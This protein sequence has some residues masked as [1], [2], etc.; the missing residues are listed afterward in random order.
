MDS[1]YGVSCTKSSYHLPA[2]ATYPTFGKDK[3]SLE[4]ILAFEQ[5]VQQFEEASESSYPN[6]L[7]SATLIRCCHA[8][9]REYLQLTVTD[10]TTY[11]DIR[12]AILSHDRASKV[13]SQETVMRSLT[14]GQ[15][16][17]R[18]DGPT[19]MEVD[20]IE[21]GG[22]RKEKGKYKGKSKGGEWPTAC[23][24]LRGKGR[25]R[26]FKGKGKDKGKGNSKGKSESKNKGKNKGKG[27][28]GQNQC[29]ECLQY[30][31]WDRDCPNRMRV[32]Q[33]EQNDQAR[34][35]Q[36]DQGAQP[37]MQ[38][39]GGQRGACGSSTAASSSNSTVRRVFNIGMPS[40]SSTHLWHQVQCVLYLKK[41]L[42][43]TW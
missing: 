16:E 9:V 7:K 24:Y 10:S 29:S 23:G 2:L 27:K 34:Q 19:P 17:Q 36:P 33:V 22:K 25:G 1:C 15:G 32:N 30:G 3:S 4:C 14:Q 41:S 5:M 37:Q 39:P 13:W 35:Q 31:H 20:R 43:T 28:L 26:G 8:K 6:E 12:E 38:F 42:T 11:A 21:K 18:T 40:L